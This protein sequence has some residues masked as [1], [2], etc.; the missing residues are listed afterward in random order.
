MSYFASFGLTLFFLGVLLL[1][2]SRKNRKFLWFGIPIL[3][4]GAFM[5]INVITKDVDTNLIGMEILKDEP[6]EFIVEFHYFPTKA[7]AF[8]FYDQKGVKEFLLLAKYEGKAEDFFKMIN[9]KPTPDGGK[10]VAFLENTEK[11]ESAQIVFQDFYMTHK[12]FTVYNSYQQK[13]K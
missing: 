4:I 2:K 13:K 1:L 3:I 12:L 7:E 10:R 6:E 9:I 8:T 11:K 5:V